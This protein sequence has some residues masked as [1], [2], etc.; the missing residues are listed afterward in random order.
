M[1]AV[2]RPSCFIWID[3]QRRLRAALP[4]KLAVSNLDEK[5]RNPRFRRPINNGTVFMPECYGWSRDG[6]DQ[7]AA[8]RSLPRDDADRQR[9][10]GGKADEC[11][12]A[13]RKPA[14]A[15]L[16]GAAENG[17]VRKARHRTGAGG[18]CHSTVYGGRTVFRWSRTDYGDRRGN[19]QPPDRNAADRGPAGAGQRLP[20]EALRA[21]SDGAAEP[22][23]VVLRRDLTDRGRL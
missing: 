1:T 19:P 7:F 13:G 11:D 2:T 6:P 8:G 10:G 14:A 23:S 17:A 9:D 3:L 21:I 20:A 22:Q 18:C 16:S 5:D 15:R 4:R 12:A